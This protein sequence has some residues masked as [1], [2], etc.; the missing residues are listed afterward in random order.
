MVHAWG[1]THEF[2]VSWVPLFIES[3]LTKTADIIWFDF[4]TPRKPNLPVLPHAINLNDL[5]MCAADTLNHID[6]VLVISIK[7]QWLLSILSGNHMN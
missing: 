5:D 4:K 7:T 6:D 1:D 2:G 3:Q